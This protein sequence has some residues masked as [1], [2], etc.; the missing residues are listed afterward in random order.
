MA[1]EVINYSGTDQNNWWTNKWRGLSNRYYKYKRYFLWYLHCRL[2]TIEPDYTKLPP[3]CIPIL[4]NNFNRLDLLKK[5]IEWLLNLDDKVA[6]L[7]VDNL[8]TYPPLLDYYKNIDHPLVQVIYLNFN[9]WRKGV[10]YIGRKKLPG[11][12]KYI[13]TDSDLL[14]YHNTPKNIVGHLSMLLDQYPEYNHIGSSLEIDDLPDYN[15]LKETIIRHE[16]IFWPPL[17]KCLNNEV[18]VAK[19][20]TTFAM[21]RNSSTPLDTE[22][23]LRAVRPYTLK[24]VDWYLNPKN[25]TQEFKYYLRSC[26]SFATWAHESKRKKKT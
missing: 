5:Q 13:I 17:A 16:S 11:F 23:A 1:E 21:Y 9:S 20:D 19:I 26:K 10:E 2:H 24:H 14:P 18:Y 25:H 6:I 22:P 3:D 4:I 8:S 12:K 15:P 7:I